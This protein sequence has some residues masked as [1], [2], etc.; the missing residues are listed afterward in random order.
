MD[1]GSG[2]GMRPPSVLVMA[3]HLFY[4]CSFS[5]FPLGKFGSPYLGKATATARVALPVPNSARGIFVCPNKGMAASAR[6]L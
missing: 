1:A 6:D 4:L 5:F 3:C 2:E